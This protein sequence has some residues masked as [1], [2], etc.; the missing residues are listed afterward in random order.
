MIAPTGAYSTSDGALVNLG[1]NYWSVDTIG[2]AMWFDPWSGTELSIAAGV[3][4]NTKTPDTDCRTGTEFH[5]DFAANRFLSDGFALG[6]RGYYYEQITADSGAGATL[7][8]FKSSSYGLGPGFVWI[9]QF[10]RGQ[11]SVL[12][13]WMR[14]L[15]AENRF[16]SD[17]VTLT[18][19]WQF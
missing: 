17:S 12:G 10:A 3:M 4:V 8:D 18:G 7:G 1:R 11:L 13:K 19:G 2:S 5:T 16:E 9:P 6:L 15:D 14:D